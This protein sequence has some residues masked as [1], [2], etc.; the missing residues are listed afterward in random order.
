[1]SLI[2]QT[3]GGTSLASPGLVHAAVE[4]IACAV[5][6]GRQATVVASAS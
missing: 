1:M 5:N 6:S 4:H 3:F 2:I